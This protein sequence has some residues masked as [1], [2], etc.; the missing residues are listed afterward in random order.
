MSKR[1]TIKSIAAALGIS[2]MTV[3]RA[4]SNHQRRPIRPLAEPRDGEARTFP[5][6]P[7]HLVRR[8]LV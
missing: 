2:H 4:L 1:V 8:A 3:S 7:A 6:F 5:P